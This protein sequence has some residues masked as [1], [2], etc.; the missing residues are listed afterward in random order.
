MMVP[1]GQPAW[2]NANGNLRQT[3]QIGCDNFVEWRYR[4]EKKSAS[5]GIPKPL[6]NVAEAAR[7]V[8]LKLIAEPNRLQGK[9]EAG[10]EVM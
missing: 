5:N 2:R 6:I 8:T 3:I 10:T 9:T 7:L 4:A 1:I